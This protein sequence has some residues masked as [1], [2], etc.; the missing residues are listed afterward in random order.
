MR[1]IFGEEHQFVGVLRS[2]SQALF[3]GID[4]PL[5]KHLISM[6]FAEHRNSSIAMSDFSVRMFVQTFIMH[7]FRCSWI[8]RVVHINR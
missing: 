3:V 2:L 6:A 5:V 4:V 8:M 7:N 1:I